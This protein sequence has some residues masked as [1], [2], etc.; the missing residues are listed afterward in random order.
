[1]QSYVSLLFSELEQGFSTDPGISSSS[2]RTLPLPQLGSTILIQFNILFLKL[3]ID[4]FGRHQAT[5]SR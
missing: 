1:M 3:R 5:I 2:V 4:A